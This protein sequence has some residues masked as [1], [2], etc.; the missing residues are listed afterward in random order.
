MMADADIGAALGLAPE[1]QDENIVSFEIY[2]GA[3][4]KLLMTSTHA[5]YNTNL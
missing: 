4:G 5:L 1:G 2:L 3:A